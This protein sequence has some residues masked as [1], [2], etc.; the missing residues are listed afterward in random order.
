MTNTQ[1]GWLL[2]P[3]LLILLG[4]TGWWMKSG[5]EHWTSTLKYDCTRHVPDLR[6][7]LESLQHG[8]E[9]LA[10]SIEDLKRSG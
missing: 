4:L 7:R 10:S 5:F 8:Q 6:S 9:R 2:A 3:Q 1:F